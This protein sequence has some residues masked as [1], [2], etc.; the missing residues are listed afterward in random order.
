VF[1]FN[2]VLERQDLDK[3]IETKPTAVTGDDNLSGESMYIFDSGISD[4]GLSMQSLQSLT[5]GSNFGKS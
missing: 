1:F 3:L 4:S 2:N 5:G